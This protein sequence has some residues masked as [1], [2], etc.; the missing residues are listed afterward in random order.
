[1]VDFD[2]PSQKHV[3]HWPPNLVVFRKFKITRAPSRTYC[4]IYKIEN[5]GKIGQTGSLTMAK[6]VIYYGSQLH[7]WVCLPPPNRGTVDMPTYSAIFR[8]LQ[9]S[10]TRLNAHGFEQKWVRQNDPK[11]PF[12][13]EAH[14]PR[15]ITLEIVRFGQKWPKWPLLRTPKSTFL[16]HMAIWA[17]FAL[18]GA[19][20]P[21]PPGGPRSQDPKNVDF[22]LKW[23]FLTYGPKP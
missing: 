23:S 22:D 7:Y 21:D 17:N 15:V 8:K 1:M 12:G 20:F 4:K 6:R 16:G 9:F 5:I 13:Q 11:W 3:T 14:K 18:P 10:L 2:T 19:G